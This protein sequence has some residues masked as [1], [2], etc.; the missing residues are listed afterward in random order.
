MSGLRQASVLG[1]EWS[2][3]DFSMKYL[4]IP[5]EKYKN[6]SPIPVQLTNSKLEIL[7]KQMGKHPS[8]VFTYLSKPIATANTRAWKNALE[9]AGIEFSLA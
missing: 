9:R 1:L 2:W 7:K 6:N 4:C 3:I 5:A 8:R